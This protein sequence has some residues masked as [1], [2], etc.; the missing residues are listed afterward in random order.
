MK[1]TGILSFEYGGRKLGV[2]TDCL[3]S[4]YL[5]EW[6]LPGKTTRSYG[7]SDFGDHIQQ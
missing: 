6:K 1:L 5:K 3:N 7:Q 2:I 4:C